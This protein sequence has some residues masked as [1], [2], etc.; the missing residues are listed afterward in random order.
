MI[1]KLW[2]KRHQTLPYLILIPAIGLSLYLIYTFKF[3]Y[4]ISDEGYYYYFLKNGPRDIPA[5]SLWFQPLYYLGHIFG[6]SLLGFRIAGLLLLQTS[7]Y[8]L[9][10]SVLSF[11]NPKKIILPRDKI[12]AYGFSA[13]SSLIF[14]HQIATPGYNWAVVFAT[15]LS[16]T[17]LLKLLKSN[18]TEQKDILFFV[19]FTLYAVL[20]KWTFGVLLVSNYLILLITMRRFT[21]L[22]KATFMTIIISAIYTFL[23]S[24]ALY[25]FINFNHFLFTSSKNNYGVKLLLR[26]YWGQLHH[27]FFAD[28]SNIHKNSIG[29]YMLM[30]PIL[31][32]VVIAFLQYRKKQLSNAKKVIILLYLCLVA[33]LHPFGSNTDIVPALLYAFLIPT[34][35][36][37]AIA[38]QLLKRE[39]FFY[40][41]LFS[42]PF[43]AFIAFKDINKTQHESYYRT[44]PFSYQKNTLNNHLGFRGIKIENN[45]A[46]PI[47][48]LDQLLSKLNFNYKNDRIIAFTDMPGF[49]AATNTQSFG[50]PWIITGY[51]N[52]IPRLLFNLNK[53][54]TPKGNIYLLTTYN[55]YP[56]EFLNYLKTHFQ[57]NSDHT[58]HT[59]PSFF[60]WREQ[61]RLTLTLIGPFTYK[62]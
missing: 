58:H 23:F 20:S 13:L 40:L 52:A 39:R 60:H 3:G 62:K 31:L 45:Y 14:Y 16:L 29:L 33:L 5:F 9:F 55:N 24:K 57:L 34:C 6:H 43:L 8:L 28:F 41:T 25:L 38:M 37:G 17:Y 48:K 27:A 10:K 11:L 2:S 61:K 1:Q 59:L 53:M 46:S 18:T 47:L 12:I 44:A 56:K 35:V 21:L 26:Q 4:D 54:P 32:V 36:A 22:K 50:E 51:E 30:T 49:L 19:L 15:T 7:G 42:M